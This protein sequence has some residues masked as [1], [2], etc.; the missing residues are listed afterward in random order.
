MC[1]RINVTED[2]GTIQ[3]PVIR[4]QG[5]F[6]ESVVQFSSMSSGFVLETQVKDLYITLL[7]SESC[8]L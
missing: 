5:T 3:I 8:I 1:Y 4:E 7:D 6:G 2:A